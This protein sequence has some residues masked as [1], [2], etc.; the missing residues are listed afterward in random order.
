MALRSVYAHCVL[1]NLS[2]ATELKLRLPARNITHQGK[3]VLVQC[4]ISVP[5]C[6]PDYQLSTVIG[7]RFQKPLIQFLV[8][9]SRGCGFRRFYGISTVGFSAAYCRFVYNLT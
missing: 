9:L 6:L 1:L 8:N 4:R 7:L 2:Y 3:S 5:S